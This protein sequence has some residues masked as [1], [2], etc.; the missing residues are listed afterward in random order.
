MKQRKPPLS[1]VVALKGMAIGV[2]NIIPGVSGGTIA[3]I[4]G[5]YEELMEAFGS[6]FSSEGGWKRNL[7]FLVPLMAGLLFG[8][9]A[10]ARL[11]GWLMATVPSQTNFFFMGLIIG[12]APYLI[13]KAGGVKFSPWYLLS[14][15]A[16]LTVVL[17]M[18]LAER[19]S[20]SEPITEVTL[21]AVGA[22][23][24]VS[25][26]ASFA[27]VIPGV[28]G[29]FIL[30]LFGMY[31]TMTAAFSSLNIPFIAV[32]VGGHVAGVVLIAKL[33]SYLLR[34]FHGITYYAIIGLVLGSVV[35]LYD[36]IGFD[37]TGLTSIAAAVFGCMVS[38][39]LGS[40]TRDRLLQSA[41]SQDITR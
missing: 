20:S 22:M 18:G 8:N 16:A 32:F 15:A 27:M 35:S 31:S 11:I 40:G 1:P 6:F 29:S 25:L 14:F 7:L 38:I 28:S 34:K 24:A 23:L 30:L 10:F 19:P 37:V 33:I 4:T 17:W 26:I 21:T 12:S 9:V 3:V 13:K 2:A 39:L 5:L 41:Q 36:G